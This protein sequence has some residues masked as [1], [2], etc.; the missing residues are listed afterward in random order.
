MA[1]AP[2][3]TQIAPGDPPAQEGPSCRSRYPPLS[4]EV[5]TLAPRQV[6]LEA[7]TLTLARGT[8]KNYDGRLVYLTPELRE[9]LADQRLRVRTPERELNQAVPWLFTLL[10]GQRRGQRRLTTDSRTKF[11]Q[12]GHKRAIDCV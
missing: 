5:L 6:D 1:V 2:R 12:F 9:A 3:Q 7:G 10:K 8:A 4:S 11:V